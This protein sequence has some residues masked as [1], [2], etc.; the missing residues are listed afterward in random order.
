MWPKLSIPSSLLLSYKFVFWKPFFKVFE[1]EFSVHT[2]VLDEDFYTSLPMLT[3]NS[4]LAR[5]MECPNLCQ[6]GP[7]KCVHEG[8]NAFSCWSLIWSKVILRAN[9]ML[10]KSFPFHHYQTMLGSAF[11]EVIK[12]FFGNKKICNF[13]PCKVVKCSAPDDFIYHQLRFQ[14]HA[15]V[16]PVPCGRFSGSSVLNWSVAQTKCRWYGEP[17]TLNT[18]GPTM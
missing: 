1:L 9:V 12:I 10:Q 13:K 17:P 6:K 8:S 2:I 14:K 7:V 15:V 5:V 3:F 4:F 11:A 18:F 16:G